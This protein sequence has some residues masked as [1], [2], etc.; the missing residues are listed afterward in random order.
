[1]L[2]ISTSTV[3]DDV[4][5][6][7]RSWRERAAEAY[8]AHVAEEV[9]KLDALERAWFP[10]AMPLHPL[11]TDEAVSA[12]AAAALVLHRIGERRAKLLGLNQPT[13][14]EVGGI[15][16][17][18]IQHDVAI[19]STRARVLELIAEVEGVHE[20]ERQAI[21]ASSRVHGN[22]QGEQEEATA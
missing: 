4:K 22:G 18:P 9:A 17:A 3:G 21:E 13:R 7:R 5:V 2:G 20:V 8:S 12:A 11:A 10:K 1:M 6:I 19:E 14:H 15:G 16:G